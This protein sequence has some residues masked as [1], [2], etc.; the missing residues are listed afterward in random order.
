MQGIDRFS[1]V[2]GC[3]QQH[4]SIAKEIVSGFVHFIMPY[5]SN[6][7]PFNLPLRIS[8][9]DREAVEMAAYLLRN[10]GLFLGR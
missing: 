2:S 9:T 4:E 5:H 10:D 6:K 3:T 8:G 1:Y 7:M